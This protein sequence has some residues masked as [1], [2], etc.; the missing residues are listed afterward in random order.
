MAA[1]DIEFN[2]E[3]KSFRCPHFGEESMTVWAGVQRQRGPR[4]I[5]RKSD[6]GS[7]R[8]LSKTVSNSELRWPCFPAAKKRIGDGGGIR[9]IAGHNSLQ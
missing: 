9:R 3:V 4:G 2:D 1:Y 7:S 6:D 8:N 5:R